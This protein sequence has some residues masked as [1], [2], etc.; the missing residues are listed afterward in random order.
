MSN[1]SVKKSFSYCRQ[2]KK[3]EFSMNTEYYVQM[4]SNLQI[5]LEK[6]SNIFD[7]YENKIIDKI[8]PNVKSC[9][10]FFKDQNHDF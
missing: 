5:F 2:L 10:R 4:R 8:L 9:C 6:L 7:I 1:K 3:V